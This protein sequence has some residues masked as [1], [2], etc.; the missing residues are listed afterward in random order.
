MKQKSVYSVEV[1]S[2]PAELITTFV[3]DEMNRVKL[4]TFPGGDVHEL[5]YNH[6]GQV[7]DYTINRQYTEHYELRPQRKPEEPHHRCR[8]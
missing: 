2:S 8:N 3:P 1:D 7:T 4:A 6:V 5:V